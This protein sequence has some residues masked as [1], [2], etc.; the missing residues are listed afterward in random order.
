MTETEPLSPYISDSLCR[1]RMEREQRRALMRVMSELD[2][3]ERTLRAKNEARRILGRSPDKPTTSPSEYMTR[4][5]A[6]GHL[7]PSERLARWL[8]VR[9]SVASLRRARI[10]GA[11]GH[12]VL[13]SEIIERDGRVCYI[14]K[15][16][17][18][19]DEEIHLDHVI[20]LARGG[21]H[22]ENNLR[23]A[24]ATCNQVKGASMP[25]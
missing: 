6:L 13:R 17:G 22:T 23:V 18:L 5:A 19:A 16:E 24:C 8:D 15:R 2:L 12:L 9:A 21:E 7:T 14:C 25:S 10:R 1:E 20:P 3:D 4:L 11:P